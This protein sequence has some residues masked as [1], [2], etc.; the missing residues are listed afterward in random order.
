M[1][2][3]LVLNQQK[4]IIDEFMQA[5]VSLEDKMDDNLKGIYSAL[6]KTDNLEMK[7]KVGIPFINLLG[8]NLEAE[9]DIKNW[10]K[11]MYEKYKLNI[12][13]LMGK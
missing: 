10:A 11:T 7:L 13:K 5:F 6:K 3:E 4:E 12:F 2:K 9:F 1:T 8:V